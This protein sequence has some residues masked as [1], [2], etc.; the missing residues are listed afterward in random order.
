MK[1]LMLAPLTLCLLSPVADARADD[2]FYLAGSAGSAHWS[3][4]CGSAGCSRD[5]GAW[6]VAAGWRPNAVVAFEAFHIDLGRARSSDFS[7]DGT[8]AARGLGVQTLVGWDFG[9]VALAGKI[10]VARL[11]IAF[12]AAPTSLYGSERLRRN[13]PIG[14]FTAAWHATPRLSFRFDAD[15]VTVALNG[16]SL[17]YSRGGDVV[18]ATLGAML[19][20]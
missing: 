14:G 16:D 20:F 9:T 15:I 17:F 18:T 2:G 1:L 4:D 10:G 19:R 13:E 5:P 8:L 12:D 11:H 3:L 7:T 6:R